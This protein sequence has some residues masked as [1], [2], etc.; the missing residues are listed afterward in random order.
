MQTAH[1]TAEMMEVASGKGH[2]CI[3]TLMN[4]R[5]SAYDLSVH[6]HVTILAA[7]TR[8]WLQFFCMCHHLPT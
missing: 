3:T 6:A 7:L 5:D 8:K 2:A 1:S 4:R